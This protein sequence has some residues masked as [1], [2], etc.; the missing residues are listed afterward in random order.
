M[1]NTNALGRQDVI[2]KPVLGVERT[3]YNLS[4]QMVMDAGGL[5]FSYTHMEKPPT[6]S[7]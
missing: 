1:P 7:A 4:E 6:A 2:D 3:P 5:H